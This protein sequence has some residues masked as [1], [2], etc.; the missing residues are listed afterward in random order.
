ME[1]S[2]LCRRKWFF[3]FPTQFSLLID[4]LHLRSFHIFINI[5]AF[6]SNLNTNTYDTCVL[7]SFIHWSRFCRVFICIE[8]HAGTVAVIGVVPLRLE[9]YLGMQH[10]T[11]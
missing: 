11:R 4:E 2:S 9:V 1:S 6:P 8:E 7:P 3:R 10:K 5:F